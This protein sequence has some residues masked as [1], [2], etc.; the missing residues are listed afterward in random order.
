MPACAERVVGTPAVGVDGYRIPVDKFVHIGNTL[1]DLGRAGRHQPGDIGIG[2]G[3]AQVAQK[4]NGEYGVADETVTHH[5]YPFFRSSR[6]IEFPRILDEHERDPV[7]DRVFQ[8]A[9]PADEV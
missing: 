1:D 2:F 8:A 3:T 6:L 5:Q 9:R 4:R 7:D